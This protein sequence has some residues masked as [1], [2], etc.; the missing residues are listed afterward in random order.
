MSPSAV[1]LLVAS[2]NP[3]KLRE[4][5]SLLAGM[6]FHLRS[7]QSFLG[8][9]EVVEDGQSFE[10]NA[11]LKAQGYASQTGLLTLAEDSGLCCDALEG[12]PG[13]Y[14]SRFSGEAKS[15][16]ANNEKLLR[17]M[18][19]LPDNCRRAHFVCVIAVAELHKLV[20]IVKG[21]VH[22]YISREIRGQGGFGYDPVFFYPPFNKT[23]GEVSAEMKQ[24]V[25][26]RAEAFGKAKALLESY[27]LKNV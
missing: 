23:F 10:E 7:L 26:H 17:L 13:I 27:L 19:N 16:E 15:D 11:R 3:K 8:F 9:Q 2:T 5:E 20:G 18:E 1:A 14:S 6:P 22:G 25:S 4:L 12:A 24:R 21:E